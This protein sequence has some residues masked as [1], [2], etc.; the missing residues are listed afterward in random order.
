MPLLLSHNFCK[1]LDFLLFLCPY[2]AKKHIFSLKLSSFCSDS[3]IATHSPYIKIPSQMENYLFTINLFVLWVD[4]FVFSLIFLS[5]FALFL[6]SLIVTSSSCMVLWSMLFI[7]ISNLRVTITVS[8][9]GSHNMG[10]NLDNPSTC[11]NLF[12]RRNSILRS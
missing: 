8:S 5:I 4:N 9:Y 11:S 6:I 12:D 10:I 2:L 3:S 1:I 7:S